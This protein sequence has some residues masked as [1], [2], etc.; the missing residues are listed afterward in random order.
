MDKE[1]SYDDAIGIVADIE[2][3]A[4]QGKAITLSVKNAFKERADVKQYDGMEAEEAVERA[5]LL[6]PFSPSDEAKQDTP[7]GRGIETLSGFAKSIFADKN[8]YMATAEKNIS[9]AQPA[10]ALPQQVQAQQTASVVQQ[11]PAAPNPQP[12]GMQAVPAHSDKPVPSALDR[13]AESAAS[14]LRR[15][16][17]SRAR[18]QERKEEQKSDQMVM[19]SLSLPDQISELE[20]IEAG[21]DGN[22]FNSEQL[23]LISIEVKALKASSKGEK[24]TTADSSLVA[25][26]DQ[27]LKLIGDEL[28]KRQG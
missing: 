5:A 1:L 12:A 23:K 24:G 19:P 9:Q 6:V 21:L 22:V 20:R 25:I 10:S 3:S 7:A 8:R 16:I 17:P 2:G 4:Q 15:I 13:Y 18:K 14:E 26:R 11:Q 28:A 27:K